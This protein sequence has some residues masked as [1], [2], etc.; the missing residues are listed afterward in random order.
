MIDEFW[1]VQWTDGQWYNLH[2]YSYH[3]ESIYGARTNVPSL[4]GSNVAVY[5][6]PGQL[7]Q[8]KIADQR[9]VTLNG[10]VSNVDGADNPYDSENCDRGLNTNWRMIRRL[11]WR[12]NGAQ[13]PLR[14]R[15]YDEEGVL[16]SAVAMAE[17]SGGLDLSE[18]V[19]EAGAWTCDLTLADPYFYGPEENATLALNVP[20]LLFNLGDVV[21]SDIVI[22]LRDQ[23]QNAEVRNLTADPDVWVRLGSAVAGGDSVTLDVAQFTARRTSDGAN[24]IGAVTRSGARPW[25][26]LSPGGNSVQLTASSGSGTADLTWQPAYL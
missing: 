20:Q 21:A 13:F 22:V 12:E 15:W 11:L 19:I 4:R 9:T 7:H 26:V 10:W 8:P 14:R 23:L 1:D 24:L 16:V 3:V 2:G 25:F 17:Y 18:H 5:G 6:R